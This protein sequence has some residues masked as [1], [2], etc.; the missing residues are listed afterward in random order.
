MENARNSRGIIH[1]SSQP[2]GEIG[3]IELLEHDQRPTFILD[4]EAIPASNTHQ[5]AVYENPSFRYLHLL[6]ITLGKADVPLDVHDLGAYSEFEQWAIGSHNEAD[7]PAAQLS[8]F[9]Y[10]G[11]HWTHTTLRKRW[12]IINGVKV[13]IGLGQVKDSCRNKQELSEKNTSAWTDVLPSTPHVRFFKETDWASTA[14]GPL[15]TWSNTHRQ[16]TQMLM[17]DSRAACMF[18]YMALQSRKSREGC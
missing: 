4:L 9:T 1:S 2:L 5:E 6:D 17:A 12:R 18:W 15:E 8:T 10:D 13:D 3:I 14:L 7:L 11:F 16:M